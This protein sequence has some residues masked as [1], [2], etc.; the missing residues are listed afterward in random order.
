MSRDQTELIRRLQEGEITDPVL[1]AEI[2]TE[3]MMFEVRRAAVGQITDPVL[4]ARIAVE[5]VAW[6][7][8]Q[9]AVWEITDKS[10]LRR[11][12]DNREEL[13]LV[14]RSALW[15]MDRISKEEK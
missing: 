5:D 13:D 4:L 10:T 6:E 11:I 2:A 12:A 15:R 8:R 1:L 14:R 9:A 3:D 7:V